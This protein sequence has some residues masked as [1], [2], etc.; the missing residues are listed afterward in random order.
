MLIQVMSLSEV[1]RDCNTGLC[2]SGGSCSARAD[3]PAARQGAVSSPHLGTQPH[4]AERDG[5]R[6]PRPAVLQFGRTWGQ[7]TGS[8]AS[9]VPAGCRHTAAWL[10]REPRP[11]AWAAAQLWA[12]GEALT[13]LPTALPCSLPGRAVWCT[14]SQKNIRAFST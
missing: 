1:R 2:L 4:A 11:T 6:Q 13:M 8:Q 7:P 14:Q 9:Q 3:E 10:R 12:D 5:C